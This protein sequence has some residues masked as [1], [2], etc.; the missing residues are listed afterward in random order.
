MPI[1]IPPSITQGQKDVSFDLV[2]PYSSFPR[3][4]VGPTVWQAQEFRDDPERWQHQWSSDQIQDLEQAYESFR[5][6]GKPLTSVSKVGHA[7]NNRYA[8]KLIEA[9]VTQDTFPL[10]NKIASFLAHIRSQVVDGQGFI[11]I[12]GLPVEN[13]EVEKSAAIY[14]AIGSYFGNKLSQ[15]GKGHVLGHVKDIGNDPT[16]IDKVRIYSY[17]W[18][19]S[20]STRYGPDQYHTRSTA[21]RQFFH[22]DAADIVGLLCLHK[23]KEGGESDVVSAHNVWNTLQAERPDVAELLAQPVWY[24]DR[25]GEVSKGQKEWVQK[26]VSR[27]ARSY[28]PR[29]TLIET[30][31]FCTGL[32]LS[33]RQGIVTL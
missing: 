8:L 11:L 6:S 3:K 29:T 20:S 12:K 5:V 2:Q 24:F 25:K 30:V 16:Q 10:S 23:A 4:V 22:S 31:R 9:I 19:S 7:V 32:L 26:A 1:A 13:W 33:R 18:H 15:N 21:A 27:Q 28:P 17:V 14:L